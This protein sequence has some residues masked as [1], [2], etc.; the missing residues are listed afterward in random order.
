MMADFASN[1]DVPAGKADNVCIGRNAAIFVR[2]DARCGIL[3][4]IHQIILFC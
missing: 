3:E 4:T 1:P 2:R